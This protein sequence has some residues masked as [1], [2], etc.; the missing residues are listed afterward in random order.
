MQKET[1]T[2]AHGCK[3]RPIHTDVLSP[4]LYSRVGLLSPSYTPFLRILTAEKKNQA[5]VTILGKSY[6]SAD[7]SVVIYVGNTRCLQV[8]FAIELGLFC[9]RIRSLLPAVQVCFDMHVA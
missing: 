7:M 5:R 9:R 3:Q 6:A 4:F 2:S 1:Y 8:S